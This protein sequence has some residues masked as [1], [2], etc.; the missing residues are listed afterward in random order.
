MYKGE[1]GEVRETR[2]KQRWQM[3]W[4]NETVWNIQPTDNQDSAAQF[5]II[6]FS[7]IKG[8]MCSK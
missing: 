4:K 2:D 3:L 8:A 7:M 1:A 5:D 6:S